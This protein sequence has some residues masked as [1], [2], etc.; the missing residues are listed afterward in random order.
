MAKLHSTETVKQFLRNIWAFE[1]LD[2]DYL[3]T[4]ARLVVVRD[5]K[6][7]EIIWLQG[8]TVTHFTVVFSGEL[9]A[10]RGSVG[11]SEKLVST[12]TKG[13]HFGL[14]EMITAATSSVTLA[15]SKPSTIFYIDYKSMRK[16]LL[17]NA[18]ICYR[19]MQTMAKAIFSL[20]R[21]LERASF[22]NVQTR[23][24]RLLLK[25]NSRSSDPMRHSGLSKNIT[26]EQLAMQIGVSRETVS[27]VLTEFRKKKLIKTSYRNITILDRDHLMEYVEDYDQW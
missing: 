17:S 21:E 14:A 16:E 2:A 26:H 1:M 7:K 6:P 15:V 13:Y 23:L 11:G 18:D 4:L 3:E 5:L 22:E 27:R 19:L 9:R 25:S 8:Q 12:L 20:T 10:V 24:A